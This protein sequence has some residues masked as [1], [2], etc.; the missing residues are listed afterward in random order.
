MPTLD[1]VKIFTAFLKA[2]QLETQ[3]C[4]LMISG[5]VDSMV[6]LDVALQVIPSE[7]LAVFH[8]DHN[9]RDTSKYDTIF[10]QN[11]CSKIKIKFYGEKLEITPTQNVESNWRQRRKNLA[12]A[13]ADDFGA[14]RILT[15]HHATDLV[16]TMI[17]RLTKGTGPSG[18]SPFDTSTK[19]FWQVP[20]IHLLAYAKVQNLEWREDESNLNTKFERNLIRADVLPALRKITPQ[21]ETVFVREAK[22]FSTLQD[23]LTQQLQQSCGH[24]LKQQMLPLADFLALHTA[25]QTEFLRTIALKTP[26]QSEV[27]DSLKWLLNNP[28]GRSQK[29]LGGTALK[30]E[31]QKIKWAY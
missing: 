14:T 6:L 8:L 29:Q 31:N 7:N 26:S 24:A 13:A 1:V 27:E 20:K 21:L 17:F 9:V 16:E 25:L 11:F 15:A 30:I 5:G 3:K 4:L 22:T 12:Q 18:L 10:V 28:N 19:P 2:E 23:F